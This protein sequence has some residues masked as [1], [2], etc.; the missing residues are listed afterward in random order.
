MQVRASSVFMPEVSDHLDKPPV[1]SYACSIR[2]S[3]MPNFNRRHRSSWQMYS[4]HWVVR[5]DDAVIGDVDGEVVLLKVQFCFFHSC[6]NICSMQY[7]GYEQFFL[8]WFVVFFRIRSYK[9]RKKSLSIGVF[10]NFQ[11][12]IYPLR[13]LSPLCLEGICFMYDDV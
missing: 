4:R 2:M 7:N 8:M 11:Q 9:P 3:L 1:Y 13:D 12:V 6:A 5:A 10:P